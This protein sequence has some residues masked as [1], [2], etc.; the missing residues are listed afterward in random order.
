[1]FL[2]ELERHMIVEKTTALAEVPEIFVAGWILF[3][4]DVFSGCNIPAKGI[5]EVGFLQNQQITYNLLLLH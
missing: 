4:G 2:R 3:K 1:M 5:K